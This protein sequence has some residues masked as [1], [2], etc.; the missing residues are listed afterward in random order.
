[1][2]KAENKE[3]NVSM[4]RKYRPD[5]FENYIGNKVLK[6]SI[7]KLVREDS[8]PHTVIFEGL[9][10]CGKTSMARLV[11][12][13]LQCLDK[14][15]GELSCGVCKNCVTLTE[16]YIL[17]GIPNPG[18]IELDMTKMGNVDSA[19]QL[20]EQ[21]RNRP[22]YP[23]KKSIYILDEVQMASPEAQN[24]LLKI[25]EEPKEYLHIILCTTDVDKLIPALKSRFR[26]FNVKRPSVEEIKDRLIYIAQREKI[27]YEQQALNS[28]INKSSR[29][30]R[31]SIIN[32][33]SVSKIGNVTIDN[34]NAIFNIISEDIYLEFFEVLERDVFDIILF[35]E[36]LEDRDIE[37]ADFLTGLTD[38]ILDCINMKYGIK[39]DSYSESFYKKSRKVFSKYS[40]KEMFTILDTLKEC[41]TF[42]RNNPNQVEM[43]IKL[44]SLRISHPD[45]F[46]TKNED[47]IK[48]ELKAEDTKARLAY[49][50][51]KEQKLQ[52]S[53]ERGMDTEATDDDIL[54]I[55]E[56]S[57]I[58]GEE[59]EKLW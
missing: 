25:T 7:E 26:I 14:K 48:V 45:I 19:R 4:E 3:V 9:R 41:L 11:A 38:F 55:F 40:H 21:M 56:N 52:E 6:K 5:S 15:H 32:F 49:A 12:K 44:F 28:I 13:E 1:M 23:L 8:F 18:I 20:T 16:K 57:K 31:V 24:S 50:K 17:Q 29:I 30:P 46:E 2:S 22:I 27:K 10:G 35:L 58:V 33:E 34:V 54:A 51:N 42:S 37:Y 36:T 53:F 47:E 59:P 43:S 39:I